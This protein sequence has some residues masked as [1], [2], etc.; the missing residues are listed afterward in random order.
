MSLYHLALFGVTLSAEGRTLS[1]NIWPKTGIITV[2][3]IYRDQTLPFQ[4]LKNQYCLSHSS[5]LTSAQL[6]SVIY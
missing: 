5:F 1:N 6:A 3:Q 4:Q 2:G